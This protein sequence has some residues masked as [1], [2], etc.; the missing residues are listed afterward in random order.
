MLELFVDKQR[1]HPP[2]VHCLRRRLSDWV[3][4]LRFW[5]RSLYRHDGTKLANLNVKTGLQEAALT[6]YRPK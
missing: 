2:A 5:F 1:I 6:V 4:E 3:N